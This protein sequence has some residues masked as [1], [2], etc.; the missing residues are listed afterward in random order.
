[1]KEEWKRNK[2]GWIKDIV[3]VLILLF[4]LSYTFR[5]VICVDAGF[6]SRCFWRDLKI[7]WLNAGINEIFTFI[8]AVAFILFGIVGIYDF[9]YLNGLKILVPSSFAYIKEKNYAKYAEKIMKIYYEK[10]IEF[11]QKYENERADYVLQALGL[12]EN[13]YQHIKYEVIKARAM[14]VNT[15]KELKLKAEKILY[16]KQF[17][18][19]LTSLQPCERVYREVDYFLN[20]YTA[21]YAPKLCTDIGYLMANYIVMLMGKNV[22]RID[23]V[24]IPQDS[25]LLLGLEVG[26]ILRKPVIAIQHEGRIKNSECWDGEYKVKKGFEKNKI[27]V[28]HDVLVSGQRIYESIEKLPS[29]TYEV[30][31]VYCLLKYKDPQHHPEWTLREHNICNIKCLLN[32][33]GE[34]LKRVYNEERKIDL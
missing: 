12:D 4:L 14:S 10:D 19:D 5:A 29:D 24:V 15:V 32:T 2:G 1:M 11:I 25:N 20:L 23:Y 21:L 13:Q 22:D 7:A 34:I 28:I 3:H 18:V 26:K 27:I 33:N 6:F 17:V 30:K 9:C 16:D 8:G 31:G